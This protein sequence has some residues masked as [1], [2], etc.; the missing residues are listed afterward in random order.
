MTPAITLAHKA[1][2]DYAIHRYAHD[3]RTE[4]YGLEAAEA[5][6]L[7]ADRVFKTLVVATPENRFEFA[8]CLVPVGRQLDLKRAA[9]LLKKKK[10]VM[11]DPR[12]AER[13]TGYLV[14]GI[15]PLGQK[16]RFP[17]LIDFS[18]ME[19]QSVYVS[20]GKR[21]LEIELNPRD[22]LNLCRALTGTIIRE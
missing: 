21:G 16:K 15:S 4:S 2:I 20:A 11:A 13:A 17:T 22:L 6:G 1:K 10:I 5:L 18:A 14:G 3:P 12:A 7:D 19:Y 8:M 9:A